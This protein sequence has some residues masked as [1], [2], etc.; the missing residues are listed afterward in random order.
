VLKSGDPLPPLF[1]SCLYK[2]ESKD[3]GTWS[4][5][6]LWS[7]G[8]SSWPQTLRSRVRFPAVSDFLSSSWSGTGS[9]QPL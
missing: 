6:P 9:T 1:V 5:S 8:Q 3:K 2:E 7:S 4:S